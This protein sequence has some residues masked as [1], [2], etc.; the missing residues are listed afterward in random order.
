MCQ[1]HPLQ[2]LAPVPQRP[3]VQLPPQAVLSAKPP[4]Q[5]RV[6]LQKPLLPLPVVLVVLAPARPEPLLQHAGLLQTS[7]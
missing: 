4:Q 5:A 1:R 3:V 2:E 7:W 6:L